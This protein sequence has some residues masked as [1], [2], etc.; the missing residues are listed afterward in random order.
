MLLKNVARHSTSRLGFRKRRMAFHGAKGGGGPAWSG[1]GRVSEYSP[2]TQLATADSRKAS[3]RRA[4]S[5]AA[6]GPRSQIRLNIHAT[7]TQ[8]TVPHTRTRGKSSRGRGTWWKAT[9][10]LRAEVGTY[11]SDQAR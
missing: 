6:A 2:S 7:T 9:V 5:A 1:R 4:G 11:R 10:L 8:P 3:A